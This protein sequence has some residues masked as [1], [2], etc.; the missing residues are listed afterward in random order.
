MHGLEGS[1]Q[2]RRKSAQ[3]PPLPM[4][5]SVC[6]G[7]GNSLCFSSGTIRGAAPCELTHMTPFS[8][9][10]I[11]PA[12]PSL[13]PYFFSISAAS[14]GR[15]APVVSSLPLSGPTSEPFT[16]PPSYHYTFRAG[17]PARAGKS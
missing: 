13:R 11:E 6:A 12:L 4:R 3:M 16:W 15:L 10:K 2:A 5:G 1:R 9:T 17:R 14:F 8:P 7:T